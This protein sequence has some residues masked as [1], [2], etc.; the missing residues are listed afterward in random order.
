MMTNRTLQLAPKHFIAVMLALPAVLSAV[1]VSAVEGLRALRPSSSL[2]AKPSYYSLA[3]AI[4]AGDLLRAHEFIRAGQDPNGLVEVRDADLT[5][6]RTILVSPLL[7]AVANG[8]TN[9]VLMLFGYGARID[10]HSDKMAACLADAFG[11]AEMSSVLR[12]YASALPREQCPAAPP[13]EPSLLS[14]IASGDEAKQRI[15]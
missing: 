14:L 11:N 6:G 13:S 2:F 3:D 4:R 7:W 12:R 5:K 8:K 15:E 1:G 9:V 10:R